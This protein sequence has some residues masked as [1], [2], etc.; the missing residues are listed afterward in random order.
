MSSSKPL[1]NII[2][3]MGK[4][5]FKDIKFIELIKTEMGAGHSI[6]HKEVFKL[7][8]LIS[9]IFT[10]SKGRFISQRLLVLWNNIPK[11]KYNNV[12]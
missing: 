12:A 2:L 11:T 6:S 3:Q 4:Q 10:N 7:N 5:W 8:C 1:M 9:I